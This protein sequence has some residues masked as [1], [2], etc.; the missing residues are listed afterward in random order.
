MNHLLA[1]LIL[2][3]LACL[4]DGCAHQSPTNRTATPEELLYDGQP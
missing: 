2:A 3:V 1:F 4:L